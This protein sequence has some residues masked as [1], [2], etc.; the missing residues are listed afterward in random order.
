VP[1]A[2]V[3]LIAVCEIAS[4]LLTPPKSTLLHVRSNETKLSH[5]S[6]RRNSQR[7]ELL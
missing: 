2:G 5:G 7:V 3:R 4:A 6:G 1:T